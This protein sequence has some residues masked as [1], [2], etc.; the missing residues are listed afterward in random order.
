MVNDIGDQLEQGK[1][2]LRQSAE[3]TRTALSLTRLFI[4]FGD[5][6]RSLFL[7]FL[8]QEHSITVVEGDFK[9]KVTELIEKLPA[10]EIADL[11]TA[12]EQL[13]LIVP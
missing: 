5:K 4:S 8:E 3:R 1:L 9:E 10:G 13:L 7:S 12:M 6:N 2:E 11:T